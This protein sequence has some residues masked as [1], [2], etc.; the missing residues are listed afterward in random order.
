MYFVTTKHPGYLLFC[1]TPSERAAVGLTA[2]K[3]QVH[4]LERASGGAEWTVIAEWPAS[5]WPH[6]SF[7]LAWHRRTEPD[8][9]RDLL[10][11]LP[12][13]LRRRQRG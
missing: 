6:T 5:E 12:D 13:G 11:V 8:D 4:V 3:Q 2:D 10:A 9:P 1:L 7:M